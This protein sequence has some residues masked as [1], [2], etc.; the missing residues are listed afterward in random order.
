[1]LER[2]AGSQGRLGEK[3]GTGATEERGAQRIVQAGA[4][5]AEGTFW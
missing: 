3:E 1:V 4:S 2:G 5:T